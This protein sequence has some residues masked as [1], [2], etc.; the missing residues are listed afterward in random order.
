MHELTKPRL[1]L[2]AGLIF[3]AA[4]LRLLPHPPNFVPIG[5]IALFAGA[6]FGRRWLAFA[7][8]FAAMLLS[9][10]LIEWSTGAGFHDGMPVIYGA[11]ALVVLLGLGIHRAGIRPLTVGV[12]AVSGATIFFIIS[13][14]FV[15]VSSGMYPPTFAGLVACYAAAIP[16]YGNTLGAD[17]FYSAVLFGSFALAER[18][19]PVFAPAH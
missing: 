11:L 15:W 4:M 9:D 16:F 7:L 6:R 2:I 18:S 17:L 5:A 14:F 10:S 1:G 8:P 19:L 12:G 13:N 3:G